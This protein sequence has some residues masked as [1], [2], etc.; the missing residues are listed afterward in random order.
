M[1]AKQLVIISRFISLT[2]QVNIVLKKEPA[3]NPKKSKR[4]EAEK[5]TE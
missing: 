2:V 5:G 4:P 3:E 1:G